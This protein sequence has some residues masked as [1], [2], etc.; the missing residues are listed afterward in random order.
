[1]SAIHKPLFVFLIL[2]PIWKEYDKVKENTPTGVT[3]NRNKIRDIL[4]AKMPI[5]DAVFNSIVGVLPSP[6]E[7]QKKKLALLC[8]NIKNQKVKEAFY[9]CS[10]APD[11]PVLIYISKMYP[12]EAIQYDDKGANKFKTFVAFGRIFCGTLLKGQKVYIIGP[13]HGVKGCKDIHCVE[14]NGIG[15]YM[16]PSLVETDAV[17]AGNILG[18]KCLEEYIMKTA[19]ISSCEDCGSMN[20]MNFISKPIIRVAVEPANLKDADIMIKGLEKIN[21]SDPSVE[22]YLSHKGEHIISACGEVHLEKSIKDLQDD[23][24]K[25]KIKVSQPMVTI[26]ETLNNHKAIKIQDAVAPAKGDLYINKLLKIKE[27]PSGVAEDCVA[28]FKI[29]IRAFGLPFEVTTWLEDRR[30]LL[31]KLH[32]GNIDFKASDQSVKFINEFIQ[33]LNSCKVSKKI[34]KIIIGYLASF[35]PHKSG[36]NMLLLP[37][38]K[39]T[40]GLA[41]KMGLKI[42]VEEISSIEGMFIKPISSDLQKGL[43]SGFELAIQNSPLCEDTMEGTIFLVDNVQNEETKGEQNL[44][45]LSTNITDIYRQA[46]INAEPRLVEPVYLCTLQIEMDMMGKIYSIIAK[47]RGK[48][49]KEDML[50]ET[51]LMQVLVHIPVIESIGLP[52]ELA[53]KGSGGSFPQLVFSHWS[54]IEEDPFEIPKTTEQL[55]EFGEQQQP[56][57][58]A[59]QIVTRIRKQKGLSTEVKVVTS[60]DKERTLSKKK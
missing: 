6:I 16:G 12:I 45:F 35:G 29:R 48:I 54:L 50:N 33:C 27:K 47:R 8:S 13:K 36:T 56:P 46:F 37:F 24:A 44:A 28:G 31:K 20:V 17:Y 42:G 59:K 2:E 38:L 19:T 5:D 41:C 34:V 53:K 7:A 14:L 60:P 55:E 58:I 32:L 43:L 26:K 21:K 22:I 39:Y 1:M 11:A 52:Q 30:S 15:I 9:N 23:Y 3:Y 18:I 51:N 4:Y 57:N 40:E 25:I 49:V 10:N